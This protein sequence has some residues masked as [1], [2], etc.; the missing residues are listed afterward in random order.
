MKPI[1]INYNLILDKIIL[2]LH[3]IDTDGMILSMKTK[4]SIKDSKILEDIFD[5][6]NLK[7]KSWIVQ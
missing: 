3:Y 6:S 1:M 4:N 2:P 7:R 5:F